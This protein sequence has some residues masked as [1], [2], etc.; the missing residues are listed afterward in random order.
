MMAND[1]IGKFL[2][3]LGI[4]KQQIIPT[5]IVQKILRQQPELNQFC[6]EINIFPLD[7]FDSGSDSEFFTDCRE[8]KLV[9]NDDLTSWHSLC[10]FSCCAV[11][12]FSILF[13]HPKDLHICLIHLFNLL[14]SMRMI[15][16][17]V[18]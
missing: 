7:W 1:D 11:F 14:R 17:G 12:S 8:G 4:A 13:V 18:K 16:N 5:N 3:T 6:N 9:V 10:A 15:L 2:T